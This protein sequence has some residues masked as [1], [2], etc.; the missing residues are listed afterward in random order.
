MFSR[1]KKC[2]HLKYIHIKKLEAWN[3]FPIN[4]FFVLDYKTLTKW[5]FYENSEYI[6]NRIV[7]LLFIFKNIQYFIFYDSFLI[8]YILW[9]KKVFYE[10]NIKYIAGNAK[11]LS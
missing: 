8:I 7:Y 2:K 6:I 10:I 9:K 5:Y 1:E 11:K 4:Y 3:I